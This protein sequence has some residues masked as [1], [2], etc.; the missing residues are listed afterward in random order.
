M[1]IKSENFD[2]LEQ[3]LGCYFHQDWPDE[4]GDSDRAIQAIMD[5][6]PRDQILIGAEV[7]NHLLEVERS[8]S[9]WRSIMTEKFGCFFNPESEDLSYPDWLRKVRMAFFEVK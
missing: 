3:L 6:E 1:S 4:F 7:I 8:E 5:A 2:V 9:D